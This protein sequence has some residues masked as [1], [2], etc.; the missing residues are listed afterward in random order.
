MQHQHMG[1][2]GG[3]NAAASAARNGEGRR[4]NDM[5]KSDII[6]IKPRA[7]TRGTRARHKFKRVCAHNDMAYA[8]APL[9]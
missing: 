4:H 5:A 9:C 7:L 8:L 2:A 1:A 6:S 3:N